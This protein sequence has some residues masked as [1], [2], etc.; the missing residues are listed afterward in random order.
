MKR[1][2]KIFL[3]SLISIVLIGFAARTYNVRFRPI[4][5]A[6]FFEDGSLREVGSYL[7]GKPYGE[8]TT[9]YPGGMKRTRY[10]LDDE[11][12]LNDSLLKWHPTGE[13]WVKGFYLNGMKAGC[14][15]WLGTDGRE[16]QRECYTASAEAAR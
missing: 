5:H 6:E 1:T 12:R 11:G 7:N 10:A 9:Y 2:V 3:G 15:V 8:W 13:V 4:R 14:W 16:V